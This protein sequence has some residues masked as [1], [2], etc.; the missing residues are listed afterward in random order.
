[1]P[2]GGID[3]EDV[4]RF[5]LW[6]ACLKEDKLVTCGQGYGVIGCPIYTGD[7]PQEAF[8]HVYDRIKTLKI[9]DKQYRTDL[10]HYCVK[11]FDELNRMG[12]I[13]A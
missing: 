7:T 3:P 13:R 5:W 6:D 8:L 12:W 9:P 11:R 1:M 2:I 10:T 4:E